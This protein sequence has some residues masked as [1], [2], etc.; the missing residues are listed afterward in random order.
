M[1]IGRFTLE[2]LIS[3]APF[4]K[5]RAGQKLLELGESQALY[6]DLAQYSE[7]I[8]V[9]SGY[10]QQAMEQELAEVRRDRQVKIPFREAKLIYRWLLKMETYRAIDLGSDNP[11]SWV[12]LNYPA[13]LGTRFDIVVNNGTSEHVFNQANVFSFMHDHTAVGG[14]MI[15]YT[16]GLGWVEHGFYNVQPSFFF[17][18]AKYNGY[19]V[20]SNY[21]VNESLSLP[22]EL[23]K[24]HGDNLNSDSRLRNA[25]IH[26]CLK[27]CDGAAF[28]FPI[29]RPY[30][31]SG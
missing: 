22:L 24:I 8:A 30:Q 23:G 17:D 14:M 28:R 31:P 10:P 25:L 6:F 5:N 9:A 12:D 18:L 26:C 19:Q 2:Y 1:A 20:L 3:I 27:R 4:F 21:L 16:C 15:H 11:E 13:D 7:R 29:Q